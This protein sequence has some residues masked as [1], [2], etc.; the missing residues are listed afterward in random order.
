M[1]N[2]NQ[3]NAAAP[4]PQNAG[5]PSVQPAA[6]TTLPM[7]WGGGAAEGSTSVTHQHLADPTSGGNKGGDTQSPYLLNHPGIPQNFE[8]PPQ[9]GTAPEE[10]PEQGEIKEPEPYPLAGVSNQMLASVVSSNLKSLK[11]K[12]SS[13]AR[14]VSSDGFRNGFDSKSPTG[15][16]GEK[17][18]SPGIDSLTNFLIDKKKHP[19]LNKGLQMLVGQT[20]APITQY[21]SNPFKSLGDPSDPFLQG[22]ATNKM[23]YGAGNNNKGGPLGALAGNLARQFLKP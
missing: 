1:S 2:V 7:T 19:N 4:A 8:A 20:L 6:A 10:G 21:E 18:R 22:V 15:W 9:L 3:N 14:R 11:K 5:S 17:F 23:F 16:K 12:G 13:T